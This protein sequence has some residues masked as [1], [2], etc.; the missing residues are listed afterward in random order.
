MP[1]LLEIAAAED[2][3]VMWERRWAALKQMYAR[4]R[5]F[6]DRDGEWGL[7]CFLDYV[8]S[9]CGFED[10]SPSNREEE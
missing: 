8:G 5:C 3:H 10:G 6:V 7:R 1:I 4:E 2:E 9:A